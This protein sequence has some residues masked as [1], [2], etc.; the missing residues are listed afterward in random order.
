ML[1]ANHHCISL[2]RGTLH[3]FHQPDPTRVCGSGFIT[4]VSGKWCL[5]PWME[6]RAFPQVDDDKI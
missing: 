3:N 4:A 2:F 1:L 5:E 6:L